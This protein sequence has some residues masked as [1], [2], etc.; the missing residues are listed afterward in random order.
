M[1]KESSCI[2]CGATHFTHHLSVKDHTVSD[3]VFELEK[4]NQCGFVSTKNPPSEDRIGRYYQ[5]DAYISHTNSNQGLFNRMYQLVRSFTL[6][7]KFKLISKYSGISNGNILDYGCGT[8]AFLDFMRNAGWITKG[9]EPDDGARSIAS[10]LSGQE[11]LSPSALSDFP[12]SSFDAITLWHVLEHVHKIEVVLN[13]FQRV[14][15]SKGI[16]VIAVPNHLSFDASYY[17]NHWAAYDVPRHLHHFNP[18][19]IRMLLQK[20]GFELISTRPMWFDAFYVS[21][22][23]EKY[24]NGKRV[25][26]SAIL[27]GLFSNLKAIFQP[28]TCSSQIYIFKKTTK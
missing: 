18:T 26:I 3:E 17:R 25:A 2:V 6:K 24:K 10:S 8:G 11:V 19:T 13:Q 20:F 14:L 15:D 27:I 1:F 22:L 7:S 4:C 5:S 9:I 23:S 28:G 16:L 12:S 21:L